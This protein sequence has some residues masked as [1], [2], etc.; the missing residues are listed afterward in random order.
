MIGDLAIT[1]WVLL[2]LLLGGGAG[3]AVIARPNLL[4]MIDLNDLMIVAGLLV[5]A[6]MAWVIDVRL[7]VLVAGIACATIGMV[8]AR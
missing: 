6:A 7:V 2:G 1:G 4:R 3:V 8:R 5:A